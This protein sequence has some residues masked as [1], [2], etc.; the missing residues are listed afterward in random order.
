MKSVLPQALR[1][2]C[3]SVSD[4][5]T[6]IPGLEIAVVETSRRPTCNSGSPNQWQVLYF[7]TLKKQLLLPFD[8]SFAPVLGGFLG[9]DGARIVPS[10]ISL[11]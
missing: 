2:S 4:K 6:T 7:F 5:V 1:C 10:V 11:I 3:C 8:A 9:V